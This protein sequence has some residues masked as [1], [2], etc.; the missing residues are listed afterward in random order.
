MMSTFADRIRELR[1]SRRLNKTE[2]GELF[3]KSQQAV[4][5]WDSGDGGAPSR[6]LKAIADEFNVTVDYVMG[7][8]DLPNLHRHQITLPDGRPAYLIDDDGDSLML[9]SDFLHFLRSNP[10]LA[11]SDY[12]TEYKPYV[13]FVKAVLLELLQKSE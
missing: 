1:L 8:V 13:Q 2:F 3:G 7:R 11:P 6:V 9:D 4:Q 12:P 10:G 5:R